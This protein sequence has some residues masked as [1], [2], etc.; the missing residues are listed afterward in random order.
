MQSYRLEKDDRF[1]IEDYQN[2][3][4]FASLLPGIAGPLGVPLWVF[5]VNRGQ[6]IASFGLEN[7]DRPILEFQPANKA[8]QMTPWLGFRTFIKIRRGKKEDFYEP[9]VPGASCQKM[10]IGANELCLED[11]AP[12]HRLHTDVLYFT[13]P[14]ENFAALARCVTITNRS[15]ASL[16]L[17]VLDGLPMVIPFGVNN[18][19]LKEI[20]RTVEAW[21]EVFHLDQHIPFY[22]LRASAEDTSEVKALEAGN[23]MLAFAEGAGETQLLPTIVD[24]GIVFDQNTSLAAPDAFRQSASAA[25]LARQ[26]VT[27]GRTPCGF[28]IL[29]TKVPDGKSV[30][31]YSLFGHTGR[32]ESIASAVDR[33]TGAG[34]MEAKHRQAAELVHDLTDGIACRTSSAVFDAY[35]RQTYLDNRL[36]GGQPLV[37]G[38]GDRRRV[39]HLYSRKHGDLERDYNAFSLMPEF[40]S[41]GNGNYRDINQNRRDDVWF[42]PS[43]GDFNIRTFMSLIQPD[44]YNPLVLQGSS[45]SLP[46]EKVDSLPVCQDD[47]PRLRKL[48]ARPFRPGA[49]LKELADQEIHLQVDVQTFLAR[50]LTEADQYIEVAPGEGYWIDHWIYNQDMIE[51]YL[52]IYP[53]RQHE[54]LFAENDLPF[55]DNPITVQPRS[56]KYVL[57][58]GRPHQFG[59]LNEDHEKAALIAARG[60]DAHWVRT[61]YGKG[62]VYRT[63]LFAKLV[64][65]ALDKF[66]CLDP[67]GMGIEM[68]A[69]RPGWCDALNG[70]PGLFGS[71]M[72]ETYEL[73]RLLTFLRGAIQAEG[74]GSVHLPRE[75][76]EF[77][78]RVVD[79][80]EACPTGKDG[81]DRFRYWDAVSTA[82]ETYRERVRLGFAG[83]EEALPLEQLDKT[84]AR[85]Q[86]KIEAGIRRA[87]D[88]NGGIPP[89][90]LMYQVDD[91]S[92]LRGPDGELLRDPQGRPYIRVKKFRPVVLPLFLEGLVHAMK[93]QPDTESARRLHR[94]VKSSPLYDAKLGMYKVN[95]PL[96]GQPIEIGRVRAFPPGWLE[97][98][99]IFLH[100][101]YKYLLELLRTG[102]HAEFYEDFRHALVAFSD[103]QVYRRSPLENSSFI[104][105]SA[106][107][108][109]SLHGAGFVA[110]LTGATAEFLSIW[111]LMMAGQA[112]FFLGDGGLCLAL[113]PVLPGWLFAED[114]TLSFTFLGKCQVTYHNPGR[115]D[116]FGGK[117]CI[118][119][120]KLQLADGSADVTGDTLAQPYASLVREGKVKRIDAFLAST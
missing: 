71:G 39:Y 1:I 117:L 41:Q 28:T 107:P 58:N 113:R 25:L 109:E 50:A 104:V 9:F 91:Y 70:L 86:E 52:A 10:T 95:A 79:C 40:Y 32:F 69:G 62:I 19:Q 49:L 63:S 3:Q 24:P 73:E 80:L 54:L 85:F 106:H 84:F 105:S 75:I 33:I 42:D 89:A 66:A 74:A 16:S 5:Y 83:A 59:S 92:M 44:G 88:L 120:M 36:R 37:F 6:A 11:V 108:D 13:L 87:V 53:D 64:C 98:E 77:L 4:P 97:N 102:L 118:R 34:Y 68:E 72:S 99:S 100:M 61:G 7:K 38:E 15:G 55:Y 76:A 48:F 65:L 8:Y 94:Q 60:Q 22:R 2:T 47:L 17:D 14:G 21:M 78:Q 27:I 90:Y 29:Q 30:R 110:R 119:E 82:R 96:T 46:I 51:S 45:F 93:I 115:E 116:T 112:P 23:F 101:E 81:E 111:N 57:A 18:W 20:S 56:K 43:V 31:I 114:G 35:C 26:Q 67:E 12:D 103:P